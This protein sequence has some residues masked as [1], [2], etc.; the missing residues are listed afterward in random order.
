MNQAVTIKGTKSG[1]ILVLDK[2]T[3][4]EDI[5]VEAAKRFEEASGFLGHNAMGLIVRGRR[6]SEQE[7]NEIVNIITE[8]SQ[9]RIVCVIDEESEAKRLFE[10]VNSP[11]KESVEENVSA[12]SETVE[13]IVHDYSNNALIYNGN[14]RSGQ[15][16]SCEQ[17][18]VI[19]GDVKPGASVVSYGSIFILGELR[20]NAFAGA[21]GD[22]NA[23]VMALDLNPLQ[24]RIADSI[25]ISPDAEKSTK[26]RLRKKKL[27]ANADSKSNE[28]EVAYIE[29]GHIVKTSYGPAFLRQLNK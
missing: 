23:F 19:L 21:G 13:Q 22:K 1:I 27:L 16:I 25:A 9:L 10:S 12:D 20:G 15:D 24:V 28:P 2:E 29:N 18:V 5:K 7:E 8:H 4:F 3:P 14:L 26:F 6:L 11:D 17:N